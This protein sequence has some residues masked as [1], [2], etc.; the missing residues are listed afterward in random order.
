MNSGT[1]HAKQ[2]RQRDAVRDDAT[3]A[4]SF[5]NISHF[6][7]RIENAWTMAATN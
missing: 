7:A 4:R 1:H 6:A 2:F 5:Y 3:T